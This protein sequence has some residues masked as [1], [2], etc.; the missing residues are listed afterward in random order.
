MSHQEYK[1]LPQIPRSRRSTS[2][3]RVQSLRVRGQRGDLREVVARVADASRVSVLRV[4][5]LTVLGTG[6]PAFVGSDRA[7]L[8][9]DACTAV[10]RG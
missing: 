2:A 6:V 5:E 10:L 8:N 9:V 4:L 1:S 3:S 7:G